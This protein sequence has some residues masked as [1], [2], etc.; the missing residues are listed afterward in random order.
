[1]KSIDY[2]LTEYFV[3]LISIFNL[4]K[5]KALRFLHLSAFDI[6]N[7]FVMIKCILIPDFPL[8]I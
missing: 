6:S 2:K 4:Y 8:N 7:L 3:L 5:T 1:M